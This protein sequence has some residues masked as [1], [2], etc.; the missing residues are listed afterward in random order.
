VQEES[1]QQQEAKDKVDSAA[2]A[3]EAE[4]KKEDTEA[5]RQMKA[6]AL[7]AAQKETEEE[8]QKRI[9]HAKELYGKKLQAQH[10]QFVAQFKSVGPSGPHVKHVSEA[11]YGCEGWAEGE[12]VVN[13]HK[14][15]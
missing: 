14:L 10:D 5:L 4:K 1:R 15:F 12:I 8:K 6:S 3:Q 7:A 11:R 2:A 9:Q 13:L